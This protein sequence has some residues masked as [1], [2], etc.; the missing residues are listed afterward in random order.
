MASGAMARSWQLRLRPLT[1]RSLRRGAC[2]GRKVVRR[3]LKRDGP[4][5]SHCVL[6]PYTQTSAP[7]STFGRK[8]LKKP[9][10][11]TVPVR[12][13]PISFDDAHPTHALTSS[14]NQV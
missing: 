10:L 2:Y 6:D 4:V 11:Q 12:H 13:N 9:K 7:G 5:F 3:G 14:R 8:E 1:R